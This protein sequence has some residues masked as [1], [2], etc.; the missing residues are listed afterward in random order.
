[1]QNYT[2]HYNRKVTSQTEVIPGR[3]KEMTKNYAGGAIFTLNEWKVLDR[4][5]ILGSNE[6]T[7]YASAKTLTKENA[8]NLEGLI[9]KDAKRVVNRI[10]EISDAGRA[11]KNDPALFALAMVAGI[12]DD[13]GKKYALENLTKVA[14][15]GTHLFHFV[16]YIQAFRG[17]GRGLR[18]GIANWY[19]EKAADKLAYQVVKYQSRDGWSHRDILRKT[20]VQPTTE[21]M[22]KI[23]AWITQGIG[24]ELSM[25]SVKN[26]P[27]IYGFELAKRAESE[28]EIVKLISEY[29]LP[30]E[31]IPTNFMGKKV[32]EALMPKMPMTAL[33]RNLGNLSKVGILEDGNWNE[34]NLVVDK[35][36][37]KEN[38][39]KARIHP[40]SIL[41]AMK[42]YESGRG[43]RGK[44]EWNVVRK[45]VDALDEAFYMAFGNVTPTGKK[46]LLGLDV[47]GSMGWGTIAGVNGLTPSVASAAMALVTAKTESNWVINGFSDTFRNLDI[48]PRMR[49]DDV[50]EKISGLTF[51]RTDC[52]LPMLWAKEN[53]KDFDAIV[54]YTDNETYAGRIAPTQALSEY[55]NQ[56]GH[57]VKSIV[58]GTTATNFTIAA[59]TEPNQLDVV[60]FDS[61][62][63]NIISDFISG[64]I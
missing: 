36:A 32:Y 15:I 34:I 46:I 51:G 61:A 25:E 21:E 64:K 10:V 45:I 16:E 18:K 13:E 28:D 2:K 37:N 27:V 1:M 38:L 23:F 40:I 3:E 8:K 41:M 49:L 44:G 60:G 56:I 5:I 22:D 20:H 57:E 39:C 48:S 43:M 31:A 54:I 62:T 12:A 7:Y 63:P 50:V 53:K 11:P 29:N 17:W 42:T 9:A 47:S 24:D 30:R 35:I 52:S 14:R 4:F 19:L 59:P 26:L 6:P 55:Q 58:V 33:I